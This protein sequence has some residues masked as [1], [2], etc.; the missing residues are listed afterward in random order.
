MEDKLEHC[1]TCIHQSF[2]NSAVHEHTESTALQTEAW[3]SEML[4]RVSRLKVRGVSL[5]IRLR[6]EGHRLMMKVFPVHTF[7][8][9]MILQLY[10]KIQERIGKDKKS[11]DGSKC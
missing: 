2:Q 10:R 5:I 4:G 7:K 11:I 1:G 3:Y 9:R 8:E 6:D